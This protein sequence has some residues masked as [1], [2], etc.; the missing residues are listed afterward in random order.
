MRRIE[1]VIAVVM[2]SL[3]LGYIIYSALKGN[4][5]GR[6]FLRSEFRKQ[7]DYVDYHNKI[8]RIH[9]TDGSNLSISLNFHHP[10]MNLYQG[11]RFTEFIFSGDSIIKQPN[12]DWFTV[13]STKRVSFRLYF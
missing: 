11:R 3:F 7:V 12:E 6:E 8:D 9:F 2:V 13:K 1:I 10:E 5:R 4:E